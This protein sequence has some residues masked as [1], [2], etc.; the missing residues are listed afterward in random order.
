MSRSGLTTAVPLFVA[1]VAAACGKKGVPLAPL[2]LIPSPVSDVSARR[3]EDAIRLRFVLPV[4]NINGP[5]IYI[6]RVEI[7]AVTVDP[8]S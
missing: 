3:V 6:D 8:G 1:L 4:K 5:G 7:Y 2:Y